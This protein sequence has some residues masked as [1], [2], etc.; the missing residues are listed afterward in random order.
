MRNPATTT[1]NAARDMVYLTSDNLAF[2]KRPNARKHAAT[3]R[4]H[5]IRTMT[6]AESEQALLNSVSTAWSIAQLNT[7]DETIFNA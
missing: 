2:Y 6:N 3:L 7:D 4:D 5:T 1:R